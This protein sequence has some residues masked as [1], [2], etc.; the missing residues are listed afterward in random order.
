MRVVYLETT[1]FVTNWRIFML[2]STIT[3]CKKCKDRYVG[4]HSNCEAYIKER[5]E[6]EQLKKQIEQE[7]QRD[8][9]YNDYRSKRKFH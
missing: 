6:F 4:C 8:R 2:R 7:K 5:D 3:V 1:Q 9:V